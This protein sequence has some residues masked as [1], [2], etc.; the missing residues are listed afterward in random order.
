MKNS[1]TN[2]RC[3]FRKYAGLTICGLFLLSG[4]ESEEVPIVEKELKIQDATFKKGKPDR[5][6]I[7]HYSS[8]DDKYFVIEVSEKAFPDHKD[9]GDIR[10]DDQDGDGYVP[11][12]ECGFGEM[13]DCDD[14]DPSINPGSEEICDGIDNDCDGEIDEEVQSSYYA[15]SD[16]DGY[17]DPSNTVDACAKPDGYVSD[18]TDCDDT[19]P[20]VN[21][22]STEICGN[23]VD[24]NC[25]GNMDEGLKLIFYADS[26]GDG[27][28]NANASIEE[29][30]PP[31]GY[32]VDNTDCNDA[33]AN[34][35][36][37][38]TEV[39]GNSVDENCDGVIEGGQQANIG[40]YR[41]G[42]IVF[43]VDATGCHGLVISITGRGMAPWGCSGTYIGTVFSRSGKE[44]TQAIV[45]NCSQPG[46]AAR[47]ASDYTTTVNSVV[48]DDW[49]LPSY[50]EYIDLYANIGI[51]NAA[52]GSAGGITVPTDGGYIW[53]SN[54]SDAEQAD[55]IYPDP[56]D[57][58]GFFDDYV[59]KTGEYMLIY[60]REF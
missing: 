11:D 41:E 18:N 5:I 53:T 12:N 28:G 3:I 14:N 8:D 51:V 37:G 19:N 56:E 46:I 48:Y 58:K 30:S 40:D 55:A 47:L 31:T 17:G 16:G 6:K 24:D 20:L 7:C 9:H 23:G 13:G 26:D 22:G 50:Y 57:P 49:F 27:F 34:V 60:I 38:A 10:L 1:K 44:S 29:C 36:P 15:D 21:P 32:V 42:G 54:D 2:F 4:C 25:D 39:C 43:K 52:L 45:Q 59:P 35:N 33:D